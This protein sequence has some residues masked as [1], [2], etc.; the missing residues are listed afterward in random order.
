M[1]VFVPGSGLASDLGEGL[2]NELTGDGFDAETSTDG[3]D[4][5]GGGGI[6]PIVQIMLVIGVLF[7]LGQLFDIQLGG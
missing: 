7:A 4:D 6:V 2:A 1:S 3:L 5:I